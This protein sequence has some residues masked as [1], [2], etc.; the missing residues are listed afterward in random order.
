MSPRR[1]ETEAVDAS[2]LGKPLDFDFS[3][4]S[5]KN[6]FLKAAMT[7]RL[8]TWD[9]KDFSKRGIPT[10]QL[11]NVYRRWGEGEIGLI[12]TGNVMIEY[13][14]LEAA[15]N[16]IIPRDAP[17]EGERFDAFKELA[18]VSKKHG[19]LI[20]AQLSHPGRQVA[21]NIQPNP[22]SAS[23]VQL[24]GNV[25]GM[26]FAKPRPMEEA[27][28]E[29]VI[30]GF[31]NAAEYTYKAGYDGVQLHGAHGY[32][33]AQFLS[34][35][36]NK[37][38]DEYGGSLSNRAR[39]IFQI[40]KAIRARV[41]DRSFILGIKVNSVEFQAEGFS[42]E[43]C[44]TLCGELQRHG[45]DFVELS[46]GTYQ[47]LGF[48]HKRESTKK[49]EAFFLDFADSIVKELSKTR[50]YVTGGLRT[51]KGMTGA[52]DTV[53]GVGL[54]RPITHEFDLPAR[55]LRGEVQ[56]AIDTLL[57]EQDFA[58]T[59]IAAGTQIRLVGN[60]KEPLDLSR[61][62][63]KKVFDESMGKWGQ[64]MANNE[65]NSKFGYVDIFG[66]KLEPFG[67]SYGAA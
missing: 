15:G 30:D 27:D 53:D 58:T 5:A 45:F 54:A 32:L 19:S 3:G 40:S 4:K 46:G 66:V 13:D 57:D 60:D 2:P 10:K 17:F 65:D 7:E 29:A 22:I 18:E 25:M 24:E 50:A 49:R 21:D 56:S 23:D 11:I 20:V 16:P 36:T 62:D 42:T 48:S 33:L 64:K 44:R 38:T 43:D 8:S 31:A 28:F 41:P 63:H 26:R 52:L 9:P 67:T 35:T 51:V 1:M 37:R 39:L 14:Q 55:I 47:E 61:E 34:Q 6:R 59:N 12:L